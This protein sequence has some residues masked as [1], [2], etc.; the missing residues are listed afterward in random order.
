MRA[1]IPLKLDLFMMLRE[2]VGLNASILIKTA[3]R[4]HSYLSSRIFLRNMDMSSPLTP[5]SNTPFFTL[6]CGDVKQCPSMSAWICAFYEITYGR[7]Q[8]FLRGRSFYSQSCDIS[9]QKP[10]SC[11]VLLGADPIYTLFHVHCVDSIIG[12]L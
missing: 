8:Q 9:E 6:N 10:N 1:I 2:Q 4:E 7:S 3:M 12:T 11:V 5:S